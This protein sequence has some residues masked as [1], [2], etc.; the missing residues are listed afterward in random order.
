MSDFP[1]TRDE[2]KAAYEKST[3]KQ[4]ME[5]QGHEICTRC[6]CCDLVTEFV[7]CSDCGG[8]GDCAECEDEGDVRVKV[9]IGRCNENGNHEGPTA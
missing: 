9:C 1:K 5:S 4:L 6:Y 2:R 8:F 3:L 7:S